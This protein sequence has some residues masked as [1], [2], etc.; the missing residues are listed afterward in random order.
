MRGTTLGL[1][2][3]LVLTAPIGHVRAAEGPITGFPGEQ[4]AAQRALE[5]RFDAEL[6]ANDLRAWMRHLSSR[7]HHVGSPFGKEVAEFVADQ[8][9]EWGYDTEIETYQVL[10]PTPRVRRLD[11]VAPTRF[12]PASKSRR[13]RRTAPRISGTSSSRP[14]PRTPSMAT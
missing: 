7:P 8:F 3:A 13:W 1:V 10:F 6:D 4:A 2:T 5:E 9:R 11:M 12:T 14:T